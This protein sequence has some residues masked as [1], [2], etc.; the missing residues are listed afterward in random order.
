[1]KTIAAP[2]PPANR[3]C[4]TS[5]IPPGT[6]FENRRSG[7]SPNVSER[8]ETF[9]RLA[10]G[11]ANNNAAGMMAAATASSGGRGSPRWS[12][13]ANARN[14]SGARKNM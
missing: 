1:M 10:S 11:S 7:I 12:Q 13:T 5:G 3:K 9:S 2:I 4:R 6:R 8:I 14:S